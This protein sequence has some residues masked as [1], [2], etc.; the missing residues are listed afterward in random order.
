MKNLTISNPDVTIKLT[1]EQAISFGINPEVDQ[2]LGELKTVGP[3]NIP[4]SFKAICVSAIFDRSTCLV[5]KISETIYGIRTLS[6]VKQGGYELEGYVSINGKKYSAFTSSQL[7]EIDGKLIDVAVIHA[8][9]HAD[10]E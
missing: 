3:W 8:R 7:F 6:N 2:Q 1:K 4:V 5:S 9:V 10:K